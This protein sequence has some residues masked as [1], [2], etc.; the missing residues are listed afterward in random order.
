MREIDSSL[1]E[2]KVL[3]TGAAGFLGAALCQRLQRSGAE[4]HGVSRRLRRGGGVRWWAGDLATLDNTRKIL[5][6]V[7]P[8]VVFHLASY[9][10]GSRDV[11][12]IERTVRDN[13]LSTVNVLTGSSEAGA[14]RVVLAG[15]MEECYPVLGESVP[16]SPYAATKTAAATYAQ[17]FH[18]LYGLSVVNLRVFMVYGPGQQDLAK[19]IPYVT[20]GLLRGES[21]RLGSGIRHIDWV[22][23]DDVVEAFVAAATAAGVD[24]A[25]LDV[26]SGQLVQTRRLIEHLT[27]LVDGPGR[28]QFGAL[29]DRPRES[30]R[31][32]ELAPARQML[33]WEPRT[34]LHEG[35]TQTVAW[36]HDRHTPAH[37]LTTLTG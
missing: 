21:P 13:L 32:A 16:A 15:S 4:V 30:E 20:V 6:E 29:P 14:G 5:L 8:D 17:L 12:T 7:R 22:Y 9:V 18:A 1:F 10:S 3:V 28:P 2:R 24:G 23:V 11:R 37:S 27:R 34:T 35:L 33:G 19:L 31:V 26:G 25:N 36:F